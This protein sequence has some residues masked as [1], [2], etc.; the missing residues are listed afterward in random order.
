[1][2]RLYKLS[3]VVLNRYSPWLPEE[4]PYLNNVLVPPK[5]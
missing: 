1:L 4:L 5:T 2:L 3:G